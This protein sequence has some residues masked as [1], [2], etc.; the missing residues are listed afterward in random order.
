MGFLERPIITY[1]IFGTVSLAVA[2]MLF[3]VGGSLAEVTGQTNT[4][5]GFS[6]KATG[7]IG[8]FLLI[9]WTSPWILRKIKEVTRER[10]INMKLFLIAR[11]NSFDRNNTTYTCKY[12][13]YNGETGEKKDSP[14]NRPRWEAGYLTIDVNDV[15][16]DD[17]ISARVENAQGDIWECDYFHSR[18]IRTEVE[19]QNQEEDS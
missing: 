6:Y 7:A 2:I 5:L 11:P 15:G 14:Y 19:L 9:F 3:A 12:S 13:L 17:L 10:R 4:I 18:E 8:G 16:A 1:I